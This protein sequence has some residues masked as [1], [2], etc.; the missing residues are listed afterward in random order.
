MNDSCI[1]MQKITFVV[2]VSF[3]IRD[4]HGLSYY[5]ISYIKDRGKV[6]WE[7]MKK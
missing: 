2:L 4:A 5:I 7:S 6:F 1:K 3:R